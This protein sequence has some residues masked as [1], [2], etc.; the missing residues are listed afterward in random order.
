M[1]VSKMKTDMPD[2]ILLR[3]LCHTCSGGGFS[4]WKHIRKLSLLTGPV[5]ED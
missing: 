1:I 4:F 2:F 3:V 5:L